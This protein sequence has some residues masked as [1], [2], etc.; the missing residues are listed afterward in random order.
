[1]C[2]PTGL[3][4]THI[5]AVLIANFVTWFP[6]KKV[7]FLAPT[8]PLVRQQVSALN[9][10]RDM[11]PKNVILEVNGQ[12][13]AKKREQLYDSFRVIFAT[14]Q[15]IENDIRNGKLDKTKIIMFIFG[16]CS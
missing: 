9:H 8:R 10:L 16:I 14:P 15:T 12:L 11:V 5:A 7:V 2:L 6:D 1:V 13:A 3:G 4:K